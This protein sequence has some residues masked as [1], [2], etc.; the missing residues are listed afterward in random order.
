MSKVGKWIGI[1]LLVLVVLPIAL[2][3]GINAFDETLSPQATTY[4][5]P[6]SP[7]VPGAENGYFALLALGAPDGADGIMYARAWLDEARA[8]AR[9]NRTEK[10]AAEN[11][12]KRPVLCDAA[13][14]SCFPLIKEKPGD[15]KAQLDAYREDLARYETLIG[16]KRYEEVLDFPPRVSTSFPQYGVVTGAHRAYVLRAA[17]AAEHGDMEAAVSAIER[18][19]AFQRVMMT[20]SR[21]LLGKVIAA[22]DCWRDLAFLSDL[23]QNRTAAMRPYLPRL[24]A[25]LKD[26]EFLVT[27]MATMV[28]SEFAF[29]KALLRNPAELPDAGIEADFVERM[30]VKFLY[31]P[32]AT[33]NS[34]VVYLTGLAA[35]MDLPV[36]QGSAALDKLM[37]D[38]IQMTAWQY[39]DNP[40]GNFLRRVASVDE[41]SGAY[42]RLR[43]HDARAYARLVALQAEILAANADASRVAEF[44]NTSD[45]RF[46]DPY[47]EKPMAWDAALKR[48]SFQAQATG[49]KSRKLLNSDKG[50]VF[51]QL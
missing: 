14:V 35:A 15:V 45:A 6:R 48:L 33:L 2:V 40:A 44:L 32:N 27:G 13:Q 23:M 31:K 12:A 11:R 26:T 3:L 30:A 5:E 24:R 37:V 16:F 1:A 9:A 19:F 43:L 21:T 49:T 50:R 28:E 8:A 29:R 41:G 36:N 10:R 17:F 18:D 39:V 42:G 38:S 46:H 47:T 20:G 22:V 4:G 7:S 34:E 25:M 51:V